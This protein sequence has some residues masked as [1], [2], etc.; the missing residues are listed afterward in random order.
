[1]KGC[2]RAAQT[3]KSTEEIC[4]RW[5]ENLSQDWE[6]IINNNLLVM[7]MAGGLLRNYRWPHMV[8]VYALENH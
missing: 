3:S 5:E 8:T 6:N 2:R 1:M 7:K 4:R